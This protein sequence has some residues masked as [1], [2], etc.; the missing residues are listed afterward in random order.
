MVGEGT[1][2]SGVTLDDL[3]RI[4]DHRGSV[5][6]L[7]RLSWH[8]EHV[9]AQWTLSTSIAGVLRGPHLHKQHADR[10]IVL[11]GELL[12]G[13]VD[14]RRDAATAGLRSSF[15]LEPLRVLT[16]PAGVLHG[17]YACTSTTALNATSHEYDPTDDFEVRFDDPDLGLAW[18]TPQPILSVRDR[19]APSFAV[20]LEQCLA[21]GM[22]VIDAPTLTTRVG[23]VG[24]GRWG[25]NVL[26]DLLALGA[27]VAVAET[28]AARR[29][30]ALAAGAHVGVGTA[31]QLPE[32]DGYVVVTQASAHRSTCE[33]LLRRGAPVFLEKPPCT[34]REEVEALAAISND[35][36]FVMHKWRYHPGIRALSRLV[37]MGRLGE[38]KR[39]VTIRT[40][41]EQ[42][43][44]DVDVL[45]HL[46]PH[47]LSIAVEI[48]GDVARV[49]EAYV[50]RDDL[51]RITGCET[52]MALAQGP[53]HRMTLGVGVSERIRKVVV[54]GTE[55]SAWLE[56]PDAHVVSVSAAGDTEDIAIPP[57]LPLAEELRV[58]VAHLEGGPRPV[59]DMATAVAI[60][61]RLSEL[62]SA[63]IG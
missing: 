38:P 60:A 59:S 29:G 6:E 42:L 56:H 52:T 50:T 4:A 44:E 16:I 25:S 62:R 33:H 24:C 28:D 11:E 51:G 34:S 10:L 39:L 30:Q 19:S 1:I 57:T 12:V 46:G 41:P 48:L 15:P 58:F 54:S 32:C 8:P 43:P 55:A 14:L 7:D 63:A 5:V 22:H 18:P 13:L 9:P 21:A 3:A 23:L 47:D 45:W 37:S 49:R 35:R 20:L 31:E 53:E 27:E 17:F 61:R 36:L 40:G 26:R 2:P